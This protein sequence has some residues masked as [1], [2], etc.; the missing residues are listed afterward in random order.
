M[1]TI[2]T[3]IPKSHSSFSLI[4]KPEAEKECPPQAKFLKCTF[5]KGHL[6]KFCKNRHCSLDSHSN[7]YILSKQHYNYIGYF[8]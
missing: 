5:K 2:R 3:L 6:G 7:V 8:T 1:Q 4:T